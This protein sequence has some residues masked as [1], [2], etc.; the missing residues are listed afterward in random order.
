MKYMAVRKVMIVFALILSFMFLISCGKKQT[1]TIDTIKTDSTAQLT[2]EKRN[3][4][5]F[6]IT[7][8]DYSGRGEAIRKI[9][10]SYNEG[11]SDGYAISMISGDEDLLNTETL[12]KS[13]SNMIYV[14]PYRYVKYFSGKGYLMDLTAAFK[15][16]EKL[17]YTQIWELGSIGGKT[18]GIPWLGHSMCLLYNKSLLDE[19]GV[20]ASSIKSLDALVEAINAVEEKTDARGIGLVGAAS[21]D[22]SW[23]VNQFIY[24]FGS[25]LVNEEGT[26][27]AINNEKSKAA[28]EFYKNVLGKHAQ[29]TWIE[30]TGIEVMEYFRKQEVA[31][32][33]QG[34]W[35]VTDILKNGSPFEVGIIALKN[36]GLHAEVGPMMLAVPESMSD[37]MKKEAIKFVNYMISKEAQEKIMNGEY[38]P[39][40]DAYYP[41][42]TP[43]RIDMADSQIFRSFP[44]YLIFIEGFQNPSIDVP[45]PK[46]ET[47]KNE[48]YE[49]GLHQVMNDDMTVAEFLEI[50]EAKGD[51][52]LEAQ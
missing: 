35:G 20:D 29:P 2:I 43:I 37:E 18:Y 40:R 13:N 1:N 21:N 36:I 4:L 19:A 34:I 17:F 10:D 25:E 15:D 45:V 16:A 33:I 48:L 39:E 41:F 44:E 14:L 50:I 32:E 3:V 7:W 23:M 26:K 42:R 51:K 31:F 6:R 24:G 22:I 5:D 12:L 46:W 27:V 38:S 11:I 30:D 52:I 9:V 8:E 49:T 47:I 28:L